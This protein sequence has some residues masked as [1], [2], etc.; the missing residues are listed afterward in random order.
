[1]WGP[2]NRSQSETLGVV[3]LLG[4]TVISVGA[5][6]VFG[7]VAIHDARHSIDV[8]SAEHALSQLDSKVSL[9]ALGTA[10]RQSIDL[11]RGRQGT[12]TVH[13]DAGRIVV[14]HVNYSGGKDYE[15]YN[16]SLGEIRYVSGGT[17]LAYQGGGVWRSQSGGGSTMISTPEMHFRDMTLTMPIIRITG[18]GSISGS[19]TAEISSTTG[20]RPI[21][22]NS[23]RTYPDTTRPLANPVENGTVRITV[24]SAYYRAWGSYFETRTDG[25]V[26]VYAGNRTAV[27]ELVST[28]TH[29][30][31]A[32][33]M[34]G[35]PI[36]LRAVEGHP[37]DTFTVTIAPDQPDSQSFSGLSWSLWAKSGRREFEVHLGLTGDGSE[38]SNVS[39]TVYFYNGTKEQGWHDEDAFEVRVGDYDGD[40]DEEARIVANLTS[41][42]LL[43]YGNLKQNDVSV[44]QVNRTFAD[45]VTFDEH[46]QTIEW[47]DDGGITFTSGETTTLGNVTNHYVGLMGPNV[48]LI[49]K[50]GESKGK[51]HTSSGYVNEEVSSGFISLDSTGK[52]ITYLHISENT[53]TVDLE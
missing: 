23:S 50:D 22:P 48:E 6:A 8:Q 52:Y 10:R 16:E 18:N 29:G 14:T 27:V 40:G 19:A 42:D 51:D 33:P 3:L 35:R 36:E 7:S 17:T 49:V 45:R 26:T 30:D 34:E 4:M 46:A 47:E 12:F 24:Q 38:G 20:P 41:D 21:Y 9:V 44:S 1:M 53:V 11:G 13:P 37:L 2:G 15:I 43:T 32:M 39:A 28:G 5:L 31:F 25:D